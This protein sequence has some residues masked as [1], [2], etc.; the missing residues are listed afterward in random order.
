[1]ATYA[2]RAKNGTKT[3][4][5][6]KTHEFFGKSLIIQSLDTVFGDAPIPKGPTMVI[7]IE[8]I[9]RK[10]G[11]RGAPKIPGDKSISHRALMLGAIADGITE[12]THLAPGEDVLSTWKCLNS[13]GVEI[14]P[15]RGKV[16]VKGLQSM[17]APTGPLHCGNSGTT[18]RLLMGLLSGQ[19][20]SSVLTGDASLRNRPMKR[21]AAPLAQMGATFTLEREQFAPIQMQGNS[22][23]NSINYQLTTPSAQIKSSILLAGLFAKGKTELSGHIGSRDHTE[24]MLPHFGMPVSLQKDSLSIIGKNRLYANSL[25]V[26]KDPSSAA[27]W[28]AAATLV[29]GST[30][31]INDVSLNP[32]RIG[33]IDTLIRMGARIQTEITEKNP[34][35]MGSVYV[36]HQALK[37][38]SIESQDVPAL[39]DELPILAVLATQAT[40]TTIIR[41]AQE[42]RIKE[43]DRIKAIAINLRAMDATIEVFD[44]GFAIT[45]PQKLQG[46]LIETFFDHR[47]AMSFAIAG[48]IAK[49]I[50]YIQNADCVNISYPQFY[51][52]LHQLATR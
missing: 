34:E 14:T 2:R 3:M 46:A 10:Q 29:P 1:M 13:M 38:I 49:D 23:L 32:T 19:P 24:R 20:F 40:G 39:I 12:I 44:D 47:I 17:K 4:K 41:G 27:F 45:G 21:V 25:L 33:L 30:I 36:N 35:P 37:A 7:K 50:T 48:L 16:Y 26:P 22:T 28:I 18:M 52:I 51:K 42:L 6:R 8:P 9:T 15:K 5:L 11:M 31:E 43:T